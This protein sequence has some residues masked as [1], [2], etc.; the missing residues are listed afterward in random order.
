MTGE[1][2]E[3]SKSRKALVRAMRD[4]A[5]YRRDALVVVGAQAVYLRTEAVQLPFP[6]F[7]R[8]A[9]VALDP[10]ILEREPSLREWLI[11]AGYTRRDEQPG[12]YWAP[13]GQGDD[14]VRID[15]LVP[16]EFATRG[17]RRDARLPG[18]NRGVARRTRGLEAS[19]YDRDPMPIADPDD[20]AISVESFVAGPAALI[21]AKAEKIAERQS[22]SPERVKTKDVT[23]VFALLRAHEPAELQARFRHLANQPEIAAPFAAGIGA[24]QRVFG[25]PYGRALFVDALAEIRD[26]AELLASYEA[27]TA[28]LITVIATLGDRL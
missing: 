25:G 18:D 23:D 16:E 7:T 5:R 11:A 6:P 12:L 17:G 9:D 13:G 22:D 8:D 19:L 14:G 2:S 1:N 28:E 15:L 3:L 4:L 27:L 26:R 24:V 20:V 21:I 10:R